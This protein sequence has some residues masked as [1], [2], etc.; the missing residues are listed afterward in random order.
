MKTHHEQ[1]LWIH[2]HPSGWSPTSF[3]HRRASFLAVYKSSQP[4]SHKPSGFLLNSRR[5]SAATLRRQYPPI[6]AMETLTVGHLLSSF[7]TRISPKF[8]YKPFDYLDSIIPVFSFC[9]LTLGIH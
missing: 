1:F 5:S 6:A 4:S 2:F 7:S 8:I 3:R 9:I